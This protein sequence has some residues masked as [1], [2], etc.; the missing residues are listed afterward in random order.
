MSDEEIQ[1][2]IEDGDFYLNRINVATTFNRNLAEVTGAQKEL[3]WQKVRGDQYGCIGIKE[4]YATDAELKARFIDG[5]ND[6][7]SKLDDD[8]ESVQGWTYV[9][10]YTI[11]P[12]SPACTDFLYHIHA[13]INKNNEL[14]F[15]CF[16]NIYENEIFNSNFNLSE[17]TGA[18]QELVWQKMNGQ[19]G[20]ILAIAS[21]EEAEKKLLKNGKLIMSACPQ[22]AGYWVN[23]SNAKYIHGR[24][25]KGLRCYGHVWSYWYQIIDGVL[26]FVGLPLW[27]GNSS[28]HIKTTRS[29]SVPVPP[30]EYDLS[31]GLGERD[32]IN[33]MTLVED[34]WFQDGASWN[35]SPLAAG[36][37]R[38]LEKYGDRETETELY[39][40]RLAKIENGQVEQYHR[41]DIITPPISAFSGHGGV[42]V[43]DGKLQAIS[44]SNLAII[45]EYESLFY[46]MDAQGFIP[47]KTKN[48]IDGMVAL[49]E[50]FPTI[51]GTNLDITMSGP[52]FIKTQEWERG[53]D[54]T[55][56]VSPDDPEPNPDPEN[57][58]PDAPEPNPP[59]PWPG[60]SPTPTPT[61]TP[62]PPQPYQTVN[63]GY[64]W[65]AGKGI[66]VDY[67]QSSKPRT[68]LGVD[69]K[70]KISVTE[71]VKRTGTML[72]E[73]DLYVTSTGGGAYILPKDMGGGAAY[74]AYGVAGDGDIQVTNLSSV[75]SGSVS[76]EGTFTKN[77]K[78]TWHAKAKFGHTIKTNHQ[79]TLASNFVTVTATG[80]KI[81]KFLTVNYTSNTSKPNAVTIEAVFDELRVDLNR[82]AVE[83]IL[84]NAI[85]RRIPN[86][87]TNAHLSPSSIKGTVSNTKTQAPQ[88]FA[89]ISAYPT[90]RKADVGMSQ[91]TGEITLNPIDAKVDAGKLVYKVNNATTGWNEES[92]RGSCQISGEFTVTTNEINL[93]F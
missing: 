77:L 52:R 43:V 24:I 72:Y 13:R 50:I 1:I 11:H 83:E 34:V 25:T 85:G 20:R 47:Q 2:E 91:Y 84:K 22:Y 73:T 64:W 27:T 62:I 28:G 71:N 54:F 4:R 46:K 80:N 89:A 60:P 7:P 67:V 36:A 86:P 81:T 49:Y 21:K 55:L 45:F 75:M 66:Q 31:Y 87:I 6:T 29:V 57:P 26:Y 12:L 17:V 42:Y 18:S 41:G 5:T 40:V 79:N 19:L 56:P 76:P 92:K 33:A 78:L 16:N 15:A 74:L 59:T 48:P 68:F 3:I 93:K 65:T 70:F 9:A 53:Y 39:N 23:K 8:S 90:R 44:S 88:L 38:I 37:E 63:C 82:K 51:H 58:D 32:F 69:L 35:H 61:P 30:T 14:E 10:D